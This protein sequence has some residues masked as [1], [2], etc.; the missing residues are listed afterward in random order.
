[1]V[2]EALMLPEAKDQLLSRVREGSW[3]PRVQACSAAP[4]LALNSLQG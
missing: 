4:L 1:V 3:S 2:S